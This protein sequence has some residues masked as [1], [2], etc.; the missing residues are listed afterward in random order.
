MKLRLDPKS[1][2]DFTNR[3][4][5]FVNSEA[6]PSEYDKKKDQQ[7]NE[8]QIH[9]ARFMSQYYDVLREVSIPACGEDGTWEIDESMKTTAQQQ[10][11]FYTDELKF[12]GKGMSKSRHYAEGVN[13]DIKRMVRVS[14]KYYDVLLGG[15]CFITCDSD[16]VDDVC[17]YAQGYG[18]QPYVETTQED[19]YIAVVITIVPDINRDNTAPQYRKAWKER[20]DNVIKD[21]TK[22][23]NYFH[24]QITIKQN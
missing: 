8:M 21:G 23:E 11:V 15:I 5:S 10:V 13:E 24:H 4:R 7:E 17:K 22:E 14:N 9:F 12:H 3:V 20:L 18:L 2:N 16:D 6:T 19:G 1:I